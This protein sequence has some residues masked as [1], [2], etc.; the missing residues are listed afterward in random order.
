MAATVS[1]AELENRLDR[2]YYDRFL[3]L[4]QGLP[5]ADR[6]PVLRLA[7]TEIALS[8]VVWALRLRFFFKLEADTA[9]SFMIPG[10]SAAV[11]A[12][13]SAVF[14]LAADAQEEWRRWRYGWL[15]SDQLG[16]SFSAPD[17]VRAEQ[18]ASRFLYRRARQALHQNPFTL[19]PLVA[20]FRLKEHEASLLNVAAEAVHLSLPEHE[21]LALMGER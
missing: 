9:L 12:A 16:D 7:R 6:A 18:A 17:P 1:T 11:K 10:T 5:A 13:V 15:L 21:V 2:H 19:G 8:N 4:A 14:D 3:E 20:F